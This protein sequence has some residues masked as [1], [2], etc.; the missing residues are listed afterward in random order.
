MYLLCHG[1][2][3]ED[4]HG[5]LVPYIWLE[6]KDGT[7]MPMS[8]LAFVEGLR[9]LA[10][11]PRMIVL[12]SCQSAGQAEAIVVNRETAL[13]SLGPRL[14]EAGIAAVLAM[15]GNVAMETVAGFMPAFFQHSVNT[16]RS[17]RRW[18]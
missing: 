16:D 5:S 15:Q 9:N 6:D 12:G 1:S 7:A 13:A 10:T 3:L 11:Q 8:G 17:S 18:L 4:T 2:V 14:V